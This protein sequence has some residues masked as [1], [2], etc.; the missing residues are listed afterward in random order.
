MY[1]SP[2]WRGSVPPGRAARNAAHA[3]TCLYLALCA[4]GFRQAGWRALPPFAPKAERWTTSGLPQVPFGRV[5]FALQLRCP[6]AVSFRVRCF[7]DDGVPVVRVRREEPFVDEEHR[8]PHRV[9]VIL[10]GDQG[11]LH[12]TQ[13]ARLVRDER[14]VEASLT[15]RRE[16]L[17]P[18]LRE[19]LPLPPRR[20]R[21]RDDDPAAAGLPADLPADPERVGDRGVPS[22]LR[23]RRE[24]PRRG[25]RP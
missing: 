9:Q 5:S 24:V 22:R 14:E 12:V 6:P 10:D 4:P 7:L 18:L 13:A 8:H 20:G 1:E 2:L 15:G 3:S 11:L 25:D 23:V 17:L 19:P 16:H 21:N